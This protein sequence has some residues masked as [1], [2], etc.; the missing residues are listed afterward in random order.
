MTPAEVYKIEINL[1][2]T[3]YVVAP[4]HSLRFAVQSTYYPRFSVDNN[5]RILLAADPTYPGPA[6]FALNSIYHSAQYP[7]KL[8]PPVAVGGKAAMP[9]VNLVKEV[10]KK[11]PHFTKDL[12]GKFGK[13]IEKEL[14]EKF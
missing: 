13:W 11:H 3:S 7:S 8:V 9:E 1:W 2:N 6:T 10:Q 5:N 12:L 4:G 14:S